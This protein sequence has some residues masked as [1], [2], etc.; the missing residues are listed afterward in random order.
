MYMDYQRGSRLPS[1]LRG[2]FIT[3]VTGFYM[4]RGGIAVVYRIYGPPPVHVHKYSGA[5]RF[6]TLSP[7]P[8][9][10]SIAIK[11]PIVI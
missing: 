9:N 5:V 1:R 7:N 10:M 6:S 8:T 3:P 11:L 4:Y 2:N